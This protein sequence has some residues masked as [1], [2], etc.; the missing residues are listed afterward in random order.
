MSSAAVVTGLFRKLAE[1]VLANQERAP[2]HRLIVLGDRFEYSE[3]AELERAARLM[4]LTL[5]GEVRVARRSA[6]R[7][8]AV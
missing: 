3:P 1:F 2:N 7:S 4:L 6:A 5:F 8:G